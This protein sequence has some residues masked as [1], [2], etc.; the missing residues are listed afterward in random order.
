VSHSG[1]RVHV[2]VAVVV[3]VTSALADTVVIVVALR[4]RIV[5]GQ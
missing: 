4:Q 3:A 1:D 2:L 5:R